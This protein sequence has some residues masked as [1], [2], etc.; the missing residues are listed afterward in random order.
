MSNRTPATLVMTSTLAALAVILPAT[1]AQAAVPTAPAVASGAA[2]AVSYSGA[3]LAGTVN[4]HGASTSYY[5]QYGPTRA[6]GTQSAVA[7]AGEGTTAVHVSVP[8]SGL[9]PAVRYHYRLVALNSVGART[10]GDRSFKTASI[11]LSLQILGAPNPVAFGGA[12]T[13]EGTLSGTGNGNRAV[14]LQQNPFPYTQGFLDVEEPH[15]TTPAGGFAFPVLGLTSA[16]QFR[17]V[18][19][20]KPEIASPIVLEQVAPL[21][22]IHVRHTRRPHHLRFFGTITPNVEGMLVEVLKL[23]RAGPRRV[24]LTFAR[25]LNA[26]S[27]H[28][29]RVVRVRR[30]GVYEVLVRVTNGAQTSAYSAPI[31]V[32]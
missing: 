30:R 28:Y 1:V 3:T 11:P 23:G 20:A 24:G 21:V 6:Y 8:I 25:R 17:V 10:G 14:V 2:T 19:V 4:P 16:T 12:A 29:R 5:F 31:R 26:S 7:P 9:Q 15:L 27:A 18:T 32:R 13:I 22:S